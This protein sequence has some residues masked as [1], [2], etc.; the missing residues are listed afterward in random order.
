MTDNTFQNYDILAIFN[1]LK[2]LIRSF[3]FLSL[4]VVFV[5]L[6]S[7]S[8]ARLFKKIVQWKKDG[9]DSRFRNHQFAKFDCAS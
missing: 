3:D 1:Y 2:S 5:H 6:F 4:N 9:H 7:Y 8:K